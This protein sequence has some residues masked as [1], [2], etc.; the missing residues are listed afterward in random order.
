M[1]AREAGPPEAGQKRVT[2]SPL[3][4]TLIQRDVSW[5]FLVFRGPGC[6]AVVDVQRIR[7]R[8]RLRCVR[9]SLWGPNED[10]LAGP[11]LLVALLH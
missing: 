5:V 6:H 3:G 10:H 8:Q 11:A 7:H 2:L 4:L 1:A 9:S